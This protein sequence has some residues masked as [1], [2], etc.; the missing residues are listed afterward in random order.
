MEYEGIIEAT[1]VHNGSENYE[2]LKNSFESSRHA[3]SYSW[4]IVSSSIQE[5]PLS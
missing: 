5:D 4:R 1:N 3:S 2:H